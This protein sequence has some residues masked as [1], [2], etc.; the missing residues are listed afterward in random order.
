MRVEMTD[1]MKRIQTYLYLALAVGAGSAYFL[2]DPTPMSKL[3]LYNGVGLLSLVAMVVGLLTNKDSHK[4]PWVLFALG[5]ASFLTADVLYYVLETHSAKVPFPSIADGFYLLMYP[6]VIAGLALKIRRQSNGTKDWA[7]LIDA[8]IFAIALFSALWVLIMDEYVP[9]AGQATA[10]RFISLSYPV[11]DLAVL[12]MAIRLAVISHKIDR[13]LALIMAA[14]CSLVVADVQYGVL[15][16]ADAFQTGSI[17]DAFWLGFYV[18]FALASLNRSA[19]RE[20]VVGSTGAERL[21]TGRLVLMFLATLLVPVVDL[22]WGNSGDRNVTL[23]SSAVLF[24]LMLGR[25]I[26]LVRSV[27]QGRERLHTEARHDPL[28]GLANRTQF[29]ELTAKAIGSGPSSVAVLLIDLDDFKTVNDS[30]GHEAGDRVLSTVAERLVHCVRDTDLVARLGGDEFAVLVTKLIDRQDAANTASRIIRALNEPIALADRHV[31]VGGSV[32]VA[33]QSEDHDDV[34]S[35]LRGADVAMYLAKHQGKGCYVFFEQRQYAE[36]VDRLELKADLENALA[37]NQ[38]EVYYQPIVDTD[39]AIVR[40]VEAL[41]RWNHP[42]RGMISPALF[43]PLAEETG[44]INAIGQWVLNVTCRQVREWQLTVPHCGE[45]R[46]SVNLSARQLHDKGLLHIVTDAIRTSGLSPEYLMLEVTE[47]LL[48]ADS[49]STRTLQQLTALK[50]RIAVDD[51]GT[52][53]SSLS[54]LHSFPVDTIK[55]DQSFVQKIED[56]STSN[57]L[58]RTVIDLARAVGGTTVAEGVETQGQL[59]ILS[60]LK[61]DLVQGFLYSRPIRAAEFTEFLIRRNQKEQFL[62]LPVRA[63]AE[64]GTSGALAGATRVEIV[65]GLRNIE[66]VVADLDELHRTVGAPISSRWR[67]MASWF[68]LHPDADPQCVLVRAPSGRL[69]AAAILAR[70]RHGGETRFFALDHQMANVAS[71][72]ARNEQSASQLARSVADL[73]RSVDG[74]WTLEVGQ[75]A[76]TNEITRALRTQLPGLTLAEQLPVPQVLLRPGMTM[77]ELLSRGMRKQLRRAHTRLDHHAKSWEVQF[78]RGTGSIMALLPEIESVHISRDHARRNGSDLDNA[79]DRRFWQET[80]V[81][82]TYSDELE[83]ATLTIDGSI[84][85]YVI[86]M[87]DGPSYRVFDGRMN[88]A[89]SGYSP[90]RILEAATLE[91]VVSD[92]SFTTFDWMTGV[93]PETILAANYWESRSTLRTSSVQEPKKRLVPERSTSMRTRTEDLV[94]T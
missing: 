78:H 44:E 43:I 73:V 65:R 54:Y 71:L 50:V 34:H 69:D 76:G 82:H 5:Q 92:N 90:G 42:V 2:V 24:A 67:W 77:D 32:G 16:A 57:A 68:Q 61:C 88:G 31:R 48:V 59:D 79:L 52:G 28:T 55:I 39:S 87:I 80:V 30:L 86:A 20:V 10:E 15:N 74:P 18:L 11:M 13:S 84:A 66:S 6:L 8:G 33:I 27:E 40:S 63:L 83:L 62:P 75:V 41:L 53:Y 21:S 49:V 4:A 1:T 12:F 29:A 22:L 51:F 35:L 46:A 89:F 72:F 47:S 19:S 56:S 70:Q 14:L 58:V 26:G 60:D 91:R 9:I 23:P 64:S 45:L 85:S 93:A 36:I 94:R 37:A 7:G 17:V 81:V 3:V 38:L 25:V